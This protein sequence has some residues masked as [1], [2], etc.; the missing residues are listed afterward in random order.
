LFSIRKEMADRRIVE[1]FRLHRG[2]YNLADLKKKVLSEGYTQQEITDALTQLDQQS[3]GSPPTVNATINKLDAMSFSESEK[4][5]PRGIIKK[6]RRWVVA[7]LLSFFFGWLGA[8]RLYSGYPF[9][10][11]FKFLLFAGAIVGWFF[12]DSITLTLL[13]NPLYITI[14]TWVFGGLFGLVWLVD[15]VLIILKKGFRKVIWI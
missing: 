6:E 3:S 9:L 8:D 12:A 13:I 2:N 5:S 14:A 1:Y 10:G 15:L 11:F 4:S 7:L